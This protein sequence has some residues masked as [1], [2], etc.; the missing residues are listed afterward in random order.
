MSVDFL[1]S[2]FELEDASDKTID[3]FVCQVDDLSPPFTLQIKIIPI[4]EYRKIFEKLNKQDT[5][6]FRK[7]NSLNDKVDRDYLRRVVSGWSG[8]STENWNSLVKDGRVL[9]GPKNGTIEYSEDAC[10]YIYRNSW[11][12]DFSNKIFDVLK[13]GA[14]EQ[15]EEEEKLKNA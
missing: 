13:S 6:G 10:F 9:K 2:G 12:D 8:L 15:E 1:P 4:K 14:E 7:S 3:C 5:G 11:P